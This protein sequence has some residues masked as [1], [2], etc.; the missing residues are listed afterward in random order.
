MGVD[1]SSKRKKYINEWE[2][3]TDKDEMEKIMIGWQ[4]KHF[5]QANETPL[6]TLT[7]KDR[8]DSEVFKEQSLMEN[9]IRPLIYHLK[10]EMF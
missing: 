8:F 5:S 6:A 7:W 3:I 1:L 4:R 9:M 10:L 2:S